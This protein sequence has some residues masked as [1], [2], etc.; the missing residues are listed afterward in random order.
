MASAPRSRVGARTGGREK[1]SSKKG[2]NC[3]FSGLC[4]DAGTKLAEVNSNHP[5]ISQRKKQARL[6]AEMNK[7]KQQEI[8]TYQVLLPYHQSNC[9]RDRFMISKTLEAI[10][11]HTFLQLLQQRFQE[12]A[13]EQERT[14]RRQKV[15]EE[16]ARRLREELADKAKRREEL[17]VQRP[18]LSR[19]HNFFFL[20]V[21]WSAPYEFV[22]V[23]VCWFV[24]FQ[25]HMHVPVT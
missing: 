9:T 22:C 8:K 3:A 6:V 25:K 21:C 16:N 11:F 17:W 24:P 15:R 19:M 20:S 13:E 18:S 10:C 1:G 7:K 2:S 14:I 4:S 12:K 5:I 23:K